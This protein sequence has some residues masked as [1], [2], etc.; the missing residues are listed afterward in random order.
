MTNFYEKSEKK[1]NDLVIYF[2]SFRCFSLKFFLTHGQKEF[3]SMKNSKSNRTFY[4]IILL[5][6]QLL[7][8]TNSIN[9]FLTFYQ[10]H[11]QETYFS[12]MKFVKHYGQEVSTSLG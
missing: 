10:T 2:P 4:Q 1:M 5:F 7:V 6:F 3:Y 11:P 12:F 9:H 8:Q